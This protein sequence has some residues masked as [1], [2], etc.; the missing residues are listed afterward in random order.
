LSRV[1]LLTLSGNYSTAVNKVSTYNTKPQDKIINPALHATACVGEYFSTPICNQ[2]NVLSMTPSI[3]LPAGLY[4]D[5]G[6]LVGVAADI[7]EI[8]QVHE[9]MITTQNRDGSSS[10]INMLLGVVKSEIDL[11][12]ATPGTDPQLDIILS[13]PYCCQVFDGGFGAYCYLGSACQWY[14]DYQCSDPDQ[15]GKYPTYCTCHPNYDTG[16][17]LCDG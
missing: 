1:G 4:F 11:E 6:F 13:L 5:N 16:N 8:A 10:I 15:T 17:V 3:N 12:T 7:P 14:D 9:F 2:L